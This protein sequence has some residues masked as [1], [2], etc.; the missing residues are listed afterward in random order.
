MSERERITRR[1]KSYERVRVKEENRWK[2]NK[3]KTECN[4]KWYK[5]KKSK[6]ERIW[7]MDGRSNGIKRENEK[8]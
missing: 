3:S 6:G 4:E 2:Q 5:E 7:K 1:G 8:M